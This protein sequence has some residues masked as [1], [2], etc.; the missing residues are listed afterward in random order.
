MDV[1]AVLLY[2]TLGFAAGV[3]GAA[4]VSRARIHQAE[5]TATA[6]ARAQADIAER[7]R[8]QDAELD[9]LRTECRAEAA[10]REAQ[11]DY[12]DSELLQRAYLG[13]RTRPLYPGLQATVDLELD[14]SGV[15]SRAGS[16][17]QI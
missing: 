3:F 2:A 13:R 6:A 11:P 1:L 5:A 10:E 12:G 15:A 4:L 8:R 17:E 16:A 9:A 14:E 7:L